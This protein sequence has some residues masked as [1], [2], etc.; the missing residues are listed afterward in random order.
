[1]KRNP[2]LAL[3]LKVLFEYL[4]K[5]R[6]TPSKTLARMVFRDQPSFFKDE[7]EVRAKIRQYRG[8]SGATLRSQIKETKF[9]QDV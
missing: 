5:F 3:K 9:Y 4:E 8:K 1:M 7:E 6:E 2:Y